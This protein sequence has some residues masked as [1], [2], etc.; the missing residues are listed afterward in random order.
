MSSLTTVAIAI[1]LIGSLAVR[2]PLRAAEDCNNVVKALEEAIAIANKS[3][4]GT[5]NELKRTLNR[6]ADTQTKTT[7]KNA[8]CSV[9]GELLGT[10]VAFRA[11]VQQCGA[12]QRG[13]LAL[14]DKSISEMHTA[15][16]GA[17][18]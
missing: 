16:E 1:A 2:A 5:M 4:E 12:T 14:L 6:D 3:F 9:S 13:A 18:K 17:C 10:S 8:F 15:I 7:V 11:I